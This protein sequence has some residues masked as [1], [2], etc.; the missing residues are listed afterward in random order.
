MKIGNNYLILKINEIRI[1][2]VKINK[3]KEL[4]KNLSM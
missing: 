3:E 1:N 2:K 4:D